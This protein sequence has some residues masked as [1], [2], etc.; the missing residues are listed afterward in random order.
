MSL[1]RATGKL[2]AILQSHFQSPAE[3]RWIVSMALT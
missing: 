1:R 3:A 2:A